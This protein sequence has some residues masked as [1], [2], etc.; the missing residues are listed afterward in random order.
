MP[1][2]ASAAASGMVVLSAFSFKL[3]FTHEDSPELVTGI[4]AAMNVVLQG[5][6]LV[7]RARIVFVGIG[8][9]AGY[10]TYIALSKPS[11]AAQTG[12]QSH[13]S[14]KP[15]PTLTKKQQNF[16]TTSSPFWWQP[17]PA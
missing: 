15:H 2:V 9:L 1:A 5:L 8:A 4:P 14:R 7:T 11:E 16:S 10:A 3:A 12:K 13:A 6:T 17:N